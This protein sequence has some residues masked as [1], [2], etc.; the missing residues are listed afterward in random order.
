MKSFTFQ[1]TKLFIWKHL[2]AELGASRYRV[3]SSYM[4]MMSIRVPNSASLY[5]KPTQFS[6]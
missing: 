4:K 1:P 3:S 6:R 5:V 2:R